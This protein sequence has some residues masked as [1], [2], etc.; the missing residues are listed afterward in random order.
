MS[1]ENPQVPDLFK[2]FEGCNQLL[3]TT[4]YWAKAGPMQRASVDKVQLSADPKDG[5]VY[6]QETDGDGNARKL[7]LTAVALSK[8]SFAAGIGWA[9]EFCGVTERTDTYCRYKAAGALRKPDGTLLPIDGEYEINLIVIEKELRAQYAKK[10]PGARKHYGEKNWKWP[11]DDQWI[12]TQVQRDLLQWNRHMLARA[13][14]GAKN[15]AIRK[16]LALKST[17]TPEEIKKPFA[18]PRIDFAPDANDPQV[19]QFLLEQAT[20]ATRQ[21]YPPSNGHSHARPAEAVVEEA[22]PAPESASDSDLDDAL[23]SA[24]AN[25]VDP[26]EEAVA[27]FQQTDETEQT[28]IF[29]DLVRSKGYAIGTTERPSTLRSLWRMNRADAY[30]K[31]LEW[32]GGE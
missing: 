8:L 25:A 19:K 18:V 27:T 2:G 22:K 6:P 29:V 28:R 17:F 15:R 4:T 5:D 13:E 10:M 1:Q 31:L 7:A 21:L 16:A 24:A 20:G 9:S 12:E 26:I 11:G 23:S 3:P 32:K 30:R 14:T